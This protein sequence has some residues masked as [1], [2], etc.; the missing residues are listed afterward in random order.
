MKLNVLLFGVAKEIVGNN[1]LALDMKEPATV[2][3]L[4][5]ELKQTYPRFN[6][7]QSLMIAVNDEYADLSQAL[8]EQ[9]EIA[10]IPP[11]SGG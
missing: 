7:L 1:Q 10:I 5:G 2:N 3:S 9:D 8:S 6:N 4:L 11:V